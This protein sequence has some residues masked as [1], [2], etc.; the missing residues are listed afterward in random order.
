MNY[1][2]RIF[3]NSL[4]LSLFFTAF[5]LHPATAQFKDLLAMLHA[6]IFWSVVGMVAMVL[7]GFDLAW[8]S[9]FSTALD[10][11][12]NTVKRVREE[13]KNKPDN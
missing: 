8:S 12:I 4:G 5:A 3:F 7:V 13:R 9:K 10:I 2:L 6:S 11:A 1:I